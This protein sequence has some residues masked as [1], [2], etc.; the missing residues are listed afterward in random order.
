MHHPQGEARIG[1]VGKYVELEDAYKSLREALMHGGLAHKVRTVIEWIEAEDMDSPA[2]AARKLA[3][4]RRHPGAGRIRQARHRGHDSHHP[5]R[6][7]EQGSVLRHLPGHAVRCRSSMRATC[8]GLAGA[9][10]TEFDPQ[11]PHRVIFKLRELLGVDEMGGTMRLGAWP[12]HLEPGSLA[13]AGVRQPGNQRAAPS[14]LR[15]Q[16][17]N[18]K[19]R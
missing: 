6:A 4:V 17:A 2:T 9:N 16:R 7:R 10:S 12:C 13:R 3:H 8:A 11:T 14:P 5:V 1:V 19:S 18:T 15:I